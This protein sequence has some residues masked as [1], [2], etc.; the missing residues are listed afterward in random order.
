[1]NYLVCYDIANDRQRLRASEVLED[2]GDRIQRSVF[3][4][5]RLESELWEKCWLRLQRRVNLEEGDSI[6]VYLLCESCR[7]VI[8]IWSPDGGTAMPEP[9]SVLIF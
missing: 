1:M 9:E 3:E 4:L 7:K 2:Y 5:P 8:K 6:R